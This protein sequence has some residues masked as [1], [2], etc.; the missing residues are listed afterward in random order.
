[1]PDTERDSRGGG[2]GLH[3]SSHV[4]PNRAVLRPQARPLTSLGSAACGTRQ[5]HGRTRR[6]HDCPLP[7]PVD[8]P[9]GKL[10]SSP[11]RPAI[12]DD[13]THSG[14]P[15]SWTLIHPLTSLLLQ[16]FYRPT[17]SHAMS[18]SVTCDW[19]L[20][21]DEGHSLLIVIPSVLTQCLVRC[22]YDRFFFFF[23]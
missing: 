21:R 19:Q 6:S 18:S 5:S 8:W 14:P 1:M 2:T 16:H 3:L 4:P 7:R 10:A 20:L 17:D 13:R 11:D 9:S 15:P 23:F 12:P 22:R